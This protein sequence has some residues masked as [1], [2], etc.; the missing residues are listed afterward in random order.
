MRTLVSGAV[1][2]KDLK[3]GEITRYKNQVQQSFIQALLQYA[4]TGG[5]V[6]NYQYVIQL[7]D[8]NGN[9]IAQ[10]TGSLS[11]SQVSLSLIAS[12]TIIASNIPSGEV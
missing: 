2:I 10:Y 5:T 6:S 1:Q 4:Q 8:S 7:L 11:Y 3:S 12:F 9:V